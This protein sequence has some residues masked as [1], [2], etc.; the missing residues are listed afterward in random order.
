MKKI[1]VFVLMILAGCVFTACKID[2][3]RKVDEFAAD[4]STEMV[5]MNSKFAVDIFSALNEEGKNIMISPL[6]ISIALLM[7]ANGA[8]DENLAEMKRVLGFNDIAMEEVNA[9]FYNL[10]KSL[11]GADKDMILSF[12]NSIWMDDQFEPRVK[13]AFLGA[14]LES[15]EA[16]PFTIDFQADGAKDTINSWVSE[17]TNGKIEK[18]IEQI[19][20]DTVMYLI[21]AIY[22]KA[23]WT[24][25]FEKEQTSK[26]MFTKSD[27]NKIETYFMNS[28]GNYVNSFN[29]SE[30]DDF[31]VARL[32]Y[33]RG[34]FAFYGILPR[35][36]KTVEDIVD[37]MKEN[38]I[39]K[40]FEN[41]TERETPLTMPKFK[42][43]WE[44]SLVEV[45]QT[46]GME[47]AFVA[48]GF[49]NLADQGDKL[50][51]S[52]I[53]HNAVIE[54]SEEGT[55]AAAATVVEFGES[56]GSFVLAFDK[57][58]VYIIRDDR[59]GTILFIGKVED[60]TAE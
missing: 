26:G 29:Y 6:S 22:F 14:L 34:K 13:E 47:K 3:Y 38:G 58:F 60:P 35:G 51:I 32:P 40:Y 42:L 23:A 8:S 46:L 43:Q 57:P 17:N 50:Y 2:E 37:D 5:E 54:V 52:D 7:A 44:K 20:A 41:L 21:N 12:A 28:D 56:M 1:T 16:E 45:F 27:G 18:I 24:V 30:D 15:Y 33:G 10:I 49:L 19:Q 39:G 9:Q 55:E 48:G 11:D 59:S 36:E 53:I 25:P 31:A 4:V